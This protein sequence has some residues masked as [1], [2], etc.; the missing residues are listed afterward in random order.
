[1]FEYIL[2]NML[3]NFVEN[4]QE[5]SNLNFFRCNN[6]LYVRGVEDDNEDGEMRDDWYP[7]CNHG[8]FSH[9]K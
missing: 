7:I 9:Q 3:Y 5:N 4:N 6:V 1:M 2:H 8:I